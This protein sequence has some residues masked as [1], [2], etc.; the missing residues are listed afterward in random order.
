[1]TANLTQLNQQ[2][3]SGITP[4]SPPTEGASWF[5]ECKMGFRWDDGA[6][7]KIINCSSAKVWNLVEACLRIKL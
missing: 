6:A 3:T 2:Y 7:A 5:V 4:S 1:M